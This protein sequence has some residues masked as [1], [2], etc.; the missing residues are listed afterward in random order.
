MLLSNLEHYLSTRI[1]FSEKKFLDFSP[2]LQSIVKTFLVISQ[3]LHQRRPEIFD[4]IPG[5]VEIYSDVGSNPTLQQLEQIPIPSSCTKVIGIDGGS[6]IDAAKA[7]FAKILT[8]DI[9]I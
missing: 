9:R 4:V 1:I 6:I 2:F 7:D 8:G 5:D 3:S